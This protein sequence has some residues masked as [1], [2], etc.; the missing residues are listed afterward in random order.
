MTLEAL[1]FAE[2]RFI[3]SGLPTFLPEASQYIKIG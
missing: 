2:P 1:V 3:S